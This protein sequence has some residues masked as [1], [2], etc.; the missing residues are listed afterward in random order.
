M[1]DCEDDHS[2][3]HE[4]VRLMEIVKLCSVLRS[5]SSNQADYQLAQSNRIARITDLSLRNRATQFIFI[6]SY[7]ASIDGYSCL[8][9]STEE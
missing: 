1:A 4:D 6:H 9:L 3:A 5:E 2:R 7:C 8:I